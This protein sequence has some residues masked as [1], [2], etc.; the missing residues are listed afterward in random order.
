MRRQRAAG[1][2]VG[3]APVIPTREPSA[4]YEFA[5]V[6][7]TKRPFRPVREADASAKLTRQW[8]GKKDVAAMHALVVELQ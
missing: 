5:D 4:G 3:A 7:S 8:F 1:E 6:L 2:W